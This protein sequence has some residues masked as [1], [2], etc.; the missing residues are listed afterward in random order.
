VGRRL[1]PI[2]ILGGTFDPIHHGHLHLAQ[3]LAQSLM[4]RE[5][6]FIPLGA[7]PH[8][9]RP[10]A[11]A[12]HRLHMVRLA[13]RKNPL[14]ALDEREIF[15]RGPCYTVDTLAG[16]RAEVGAPQPL[17]LLMGSDVF[18]SLD[19]WKRWQEL[20]GLAHIVVGQR[21]APNA[22]HLPRALQKELKRRWVKK[23]EWLHTEPA[24]CI[25]LQPIIQLDISASR[26][27]EDLN[28]RRLPRYL[29]PQEVLNY[30]NKKR[31]YVKN[32]GGR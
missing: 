2:G 3:E 5:V 25:Y 16:L 28:A 32:Q 11:S 23:S 31:L 8:R 7:P 26:I 17:C 13:I 1:K 14:F 19:R 9:N 27:R 30:I 4:L 20:F 22:Q 6:R 29:L 10:H 15:R 12:T 18:A 21:P 24:G